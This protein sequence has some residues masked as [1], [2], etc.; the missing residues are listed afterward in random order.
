VSVDIAALERWS[1]RQVWDVSEYS[2]ATEAAFAAMPVL[3]TAT[4]A[5]QTL[6]ANMT[7]LGGFRPQD[8]EALRVALD[9]ITTDG[10]RDE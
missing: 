5:A 7:R 9:A 3:L 6:V 2:E 8:F 10:P 4:R 1:Q